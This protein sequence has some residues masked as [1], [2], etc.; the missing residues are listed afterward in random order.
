MD[1][2][3]EL[4]GDVIELAVEGAGSKSF[5]S[6]RDKIKG[7]KNTKTSIKDNIDKSINKEKIKINL[8]PTNGNLVDTY[9]NAKFKVS[10]NNSLNSSLSSDSNDSSYEIE[11]N[12]DIILDELEFDEEAFKKGIIYSEILGKPKAKIRRRCR[13]W[14]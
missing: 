10:S 14:R 13:R 2:I 7:K 1:F 11:E 9:E 8:K 4:I 5:D 6:L 12:N 3:G